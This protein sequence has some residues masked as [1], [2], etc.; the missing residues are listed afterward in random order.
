MPPSG[1]SSIAYRARPTGIALAC[2]VTAASRNAPA[3]GPVA[4]N[5]AMCEMSNSPAAERTA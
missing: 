2:A 1:A 4:S 5:S 3:S